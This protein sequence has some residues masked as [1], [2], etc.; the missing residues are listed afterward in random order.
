[1]KTKQIA[2]MVLILAAQPLTAWDVLPSLKLHGFASQAL[3]YTSDHKFYG[4]SESWSGQ[5]TELGLNGRYTIGSVGVAAQVLAQ[6]RGDLVD[7]DDPKL[8]YG[9][10][11]YQYSLADYQI[12]AYAGRIKFPF[13]L[14]NESREVPFTKPS[15][16]LPQVIYREPLRDVFTS[17]DVVSLSASKYFANSDLTATISYGKPG[18][19][20]DLL[21]SYFFNLRGISNLDLTLRDSPAFNIRYSL[22]NDSF[23]LN[24]TKAKLDFGHTLDVNVYSVQYSYQQH[25][26]TA[27][28]LNNVFEREYVPR[29]RLPMDEITLDAKYI[30]YEYEY[31]RQIA[32]L[33][34]YEQEDITSR[35]QKAYHSQFPDGTQDSQSYTVGVTYLPRNNWMLRAQYTNTNG[36]TTLNEVENPKA[37]SMLGDKTWHMLAF[38]MSYRF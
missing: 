1:M 5:Y 23:K 3:I 21:S 30:Q 22:L 29:F 4:N 8:D 2:V 14:Y 37:R 7:L 19:G 38:S 24:W 31:S 27:E 33:I 13:G 6:Q 9:F 28:W 12:T 17:M 32:F 11:Q 18:E 10:I 36:W 15:I 16:F 34:R 35:Y 20:L 26:F 25:K